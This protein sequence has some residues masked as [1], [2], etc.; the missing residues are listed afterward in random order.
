MKFPPGQYG[1]I[2]ADPPWA[3]TMYGDTGYDKSPQAHYPCMPQED[4]KALRDDILFATAPNAVMVMWTCFPFLPDALELLQ[5]YGFKYKTGGV[6]NK[7]TS[8]GK[9]AFGTGYILRSSAELFLIGTVGNPPL[10]NKSTRNAF[11]DDIAPDDLRDIQINLYAERREHSR[12]PDGMH[13]IISNL[14]YGPYLELFA[15]QPRKGWTVW[16]NQTDKFKEG[17]NV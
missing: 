9:P 15:R 14:F 1:C 12:K 11:F 10:K 6:W 2:M 4:M 16:G 13:G 5:H 8:T 7:L 3:Y 17:E